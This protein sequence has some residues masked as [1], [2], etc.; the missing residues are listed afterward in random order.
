M[1]PATEALQLFCTLQR[2]YTGLWYSGL[3]TA[4]IGRIKYR[5]YLRWKRRQAAERGRE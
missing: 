4:R 1:T 3:P 2:A 5:A